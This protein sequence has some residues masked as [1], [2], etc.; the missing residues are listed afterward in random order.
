MITIKSEEQPARCFGFTA[1][2]HLSASTS[3]SR[4]ESGSR[5]LAIEDVTKT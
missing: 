4:P 5:N 3:A 1:A 2:A